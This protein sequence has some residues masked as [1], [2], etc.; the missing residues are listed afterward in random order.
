M[1]A[2]REVAEGLE[3]DL[4]AKQKQGEAETFVKTLHALRERYV[5]ELVNSESA[6]TFSGLDAAIDRQLKQIH[7]LIEEL[8][9]LAERAA[10]DKEQVNRVKTIRMTLSDAIFDLAWGF[11]HVAHGQGLIDGVLVG[12]LLQAKATLMA[13]GINP[14]VSPLLG[15]VE[16]WTREAAGYASNPYDLLG[17]VNSL[18]MLE[19]MATA[20]PTPGD[21]RAVQEAVNSA[22]TDM[23]VRKGD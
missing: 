13:A 22:F 18:R 14:V 11:A 20:K 4:E 19:N 21:T 5:R 3:K 8:V 2:I 1:V 7:K 16:A 17:R 15:A 6:H 23:Y 9:G 12:G 10:G